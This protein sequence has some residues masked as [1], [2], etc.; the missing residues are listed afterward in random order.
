MI[1]VDQVRKAGNRDRHTCPC[2]E[3]CNPHPPPPHHG[4]DNSSRPRGLP[5]MCGSRCSEHR[6]RR[7][8]TQKWWDTNRRSS[9]SPRLLQSARGNETGLGA[10]SMHGRTAAR[11]RTFHTNFDFFGPGV[12]VRGV[13]CFEPAG[14]IV[15]E[16]PNEP[17]PL[18]DN[19]SPVDS[20]TEFPS[21]RK[22]TSG[23]AVHPLSHLALLI[24]TSGVARSSS[25][26][27]S[28]RSCS[29]LRGRASH[30]SLRRT[31]P[32]VGSRSRTAGT[33]WS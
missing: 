22:D 20:E 16:N 3:G 7:F 12:I 4:R 19:P 14:S 26:D 2:C 27:P 5:N 13:P 28:H 6:S 31:R 15:R 23:P 30:R 21:E 9:S 1:R 25:Q 18:R 32:L 8:L 10:F 17:I 29:R 24:G 33:R 11:I